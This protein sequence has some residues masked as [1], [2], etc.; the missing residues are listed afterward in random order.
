MA[1]IGRLFLM[2][3]LALS[4][5]SVV[6]LVLGMRR[7]RTELVASGRLAAWGAVAL[8]IGAFLVL[9]YLLVSQDFS[10]AFVQRQTAV[11]QPLFYTI[12]AVWGGSEGSLL[13]WLMMLSIYIGAAMWVHRDDHPDFVAYFT[14]VLMG[15]AAFSFI[16]LNFEAKPFVSSMQ[17][18]GSIPAE[19]RGLNPLLQNF[20]MIMH[21]PFLYAGFTGFSVPFAFAIAALITRR[22]GAG[23]IRLSRRWTLVAW[24]ALSIGIML[25]GHWAYRELGWGGYWAWDPVEN[26]SLIP[27]LVSTAFLHSVMV[28][29]S[30]GMLKVWNLMLI[31]ITFTLSIFATFLTRSGIIESI[32]AF[33]EGRLGYYFLTFI[34]IILLG[35]LLLLFRRLPLLRADNELDG[36]LSR[37]SAFLLNN[38]LFVGMGFAVFWGTIYP[39]ISEAAT[40]QRVVVGPPYFNA[41]VGPMLLATIFLMGIAPMLPWRRANPERL[42]RNLAL[43]TVAALLTALALA[44]FGVRSGVVLLSLALVAFVAVGHLHEIWRAVKA[45]QLRSGFGRVR[46]LTTLVSRNR[47]RYGGYLI[48]LGVTVMALGIVVSS[49]YREEMDVTVTE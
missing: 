25:G 30:R 18:F 46:S 43:P 49:V 5:Y 10:V 1:D 38:V 47:R 41:I 42:F 20:F 22:T 28:Q 33:A 45:Q 34:A 14:A 19:G 29:E 39:I 26:S 21:P 9:E 8:A 35:S 16:I 13:F 6:A 2:A 24:G 12:T 17:Q 40:G 27:W 15:I 3:G 4:L 48:H 37:E 23:W 31:I 11:G 36:L 32:H 7:R 44:L